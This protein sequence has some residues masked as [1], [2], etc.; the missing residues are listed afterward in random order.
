MIA[1]WPSRTER[2]SHSLW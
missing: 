2:R 1:V